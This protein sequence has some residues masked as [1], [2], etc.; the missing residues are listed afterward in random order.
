MAQIYMDDIVFGL[1]ID[2]LAF[3]FAEEMKNEFEMSM[4]GE[5]TFFLVLQV[6]QLEDEL[7]IFQSKYERDLI[8]RIWVK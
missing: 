3:E 5:L 6:K 8:K 4:V 1:S 2:T 7:F